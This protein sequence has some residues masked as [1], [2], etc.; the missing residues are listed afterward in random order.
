MPSMSPP[1]SSHS[2]STCCV[3]DMTHVS[4]S[5]QKAIGSGQYY[6]PHFKMRKPRSRDRKGPAPGYIV[7]WWQT[8]PGPR[9]HGSSIHA[10]PHLTLQLHALGF[11]LRREATCPYEGVSMSLQTLRQQQRDPRPGSSPG[12]RSVHAMEPCSAVTRSAV[13]MHRMI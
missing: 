7:S 13:V 2:L 3:P 6:Y 11:A 5:S 4:S 10:N 1:K 9:P 12:G 8:E